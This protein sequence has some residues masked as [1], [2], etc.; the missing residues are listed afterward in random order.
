M[1]AIRIT[2]EFWA[3]VGESWAIKQLAAHRRSRSWNARVRHLERRNL[4]N[5]GA[6]QPPGRQLKDT[7]SG[8]NREGDEIAM[9]VIADGLPARNLLSELFRRLLNLHT[10]NTFSSSVAHEN[11]F[12]AAAC[13]KATVSLAIR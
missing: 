13:F 8:R 6:Q 10:L 5:S 3:L 12:L 11:C 7:A 2:A 4:G 1:V 9:V